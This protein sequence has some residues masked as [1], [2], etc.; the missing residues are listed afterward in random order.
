VAVVSAETLAIV[1]EPD[2]DL[3]VLG[4]GEDEIAIEVVARGRRSAKEPHGNEWRVHVMSCHVMLRGG[5]G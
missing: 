3:L 1:R 5:E 2:A 4:D